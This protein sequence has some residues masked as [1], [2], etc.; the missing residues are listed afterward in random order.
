MDK[1][2]K[3][4]I[5][6]LPFMNKIQV[7][8]K[9]LDKRIPTILGIVVL[10]V[11]LISGTLLIGK[12]GGVFA[13]RASVETTPKNVKVT[14]V[15]DTSFT[16]SFLT[17][18]L[19]A[20]FVKY[21]TEANSL[22]S[23][24]SDDRDQITGTVGEFQIHH[25]TIRGLQEDTTYFYLLGTGSGSTFD[26]NGEPFKIKTAKRNGVPAAAKTIYGSVTTETGAP[27]E[28]SVVYVDVKGAGTMSSQVKASGSWAIPL[29]NARTTDGSAYAQILD[30][31]N[32]II[33][34]Q[35]PLSSQK[36]FFATTVAL[37]QPVEGITLGKDTVASNEDGTITEPESIRDSEASVDSLLAAS[38]AAELARE[39]DEASKAAE[40]ARAQAEI[41]EEMAASQEATDEEEIVDDSNRTALIDDLTN[42]DSSESAVVTKVDLELETHQTVTTT[43]PTVVGKALPSAEVYITVHSEAQI[44]QTLTAN[45]N[46]EFVLDIAELSET[47]EPGEHTIN[48]SYIDP[49]T[50]MVV[51]KTMNFTVSADAV[52]QAEIAA[53][54]SSTT[55]NRNSV[56][57]GS[58]NPYPIEE[59]EEEVATAEPE[60]T[61]EAETEA[62]DSAEA[63]AE[64]R[65]ENL[66]TDEG[67]PV[68]GS[69]GTTM[70]LIF[71]GLFFIISGLWSFWI[72][73]Q[74]D[75]NKFS[76]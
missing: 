74:L 57:Y 72:S 2:K 12:G 30:E 76:V 5:D 67:T 41:D 32:V 25:I 31:D 44:E 50:G 64:A 15:H 47:L 40:L 59:E 20:G 60:A 62:T 26:D 6:S 51:K 53:A 69:V 48:Y 49:N 11:A 35:G 8:K 36:S 61:K 37:S 55:S 66:A 70:A 13:P 17:D 19:V 29:S 39:Q 27:A 58:G 73:T 63:T 14:N 28:G 23:Q 43:Q 34:V 21:G 42:D 1:N 71:G 54:Q 68:S 33:N 56:P 38:E 65:T 9:I 18:D 22:N 52:S 10:V 46:G 24:A 75:K 4:S 7:P 45:E 3:N 16:I